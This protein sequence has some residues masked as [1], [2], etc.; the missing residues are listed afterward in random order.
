MSWVSV[1]SIATGGQI[2]LQGTTNGVNNVIIS[3]PETPEQTVELIYFSITN[4]DTV[5]NTVYIFEFTNGAYKLLYSSLLLPGYS[6]EKK[7]DS[8]IN[9]IK[10]GLPLQVILVS[11]TFIPVTI[12][13]V[14]ANN[15]VL[16]ST[17]SSSPAGTG[18]EFVL[19]DASKVIL[20][21]VLRM[22]TI[23]GNNLSVKNSIAGQNLDGQSIDV[24]VKIRR[25]QS[26]SGAGW[27]V[28]RQSFGVYAYKNNGYF[29]A[30]L[31]ND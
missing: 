26:L 14:N 2:N 24:S 9:I 12:Q 1:S 7:S 20:G 31:H 23:G 16:A 30:S 13:Q 29:W 27:L 3:K 28:P 11:G 10:N 4:T 21:S 19:P 22:D 17:D 18:T 8:F 5:A 6:I 25:P 15:F